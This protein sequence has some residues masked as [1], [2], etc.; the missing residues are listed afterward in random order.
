MVPWSVGPAS[1]PVSSC[2]SAGTGSWPWVP[3]HGTRK[4]KI[5]SGHRNFGGPDHHEPADDRACAV[6]QGQG[7]RPVGPVRR[8]RLVL[9]RLVLGG[10]AEPGPPHDLH[11]G[12][13]VHLHCGPESVAQ[14]LSV[15]ARVWPG[16]RIQQGVVSG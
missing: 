3:E 12:A 6:A 9:A 1:T 16:D 2:E 15:V 11:R 7:R 4:D 13:L 8:R 14:S 5:G 10:G